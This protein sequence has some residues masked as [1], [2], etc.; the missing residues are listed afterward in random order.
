VAI[1]AVDPGAGLEPHARECRQDAGARCH[2]GE[3]CGGERRM[4]S[5]NRCHRGGDPL[6]RSVDA[7]PRCRPLAPGVLR[8]IYGAGISVFEPRRTEMKKRV[9]IKKVVL[10][11]Q[12][13]RELSSRELTT[14]PVA[15]GRPQDT[16]ASHQDV[17]CA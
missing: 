8:T 12:T 10:A 2:G 6:H 5:R 1:L 3:L 14:M 9:G 15:G 11:K 4:Q 16:A 17:C 7:V 13:I